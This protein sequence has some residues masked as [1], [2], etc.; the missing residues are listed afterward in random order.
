MKR[1]L[2]NDKVKVISGKW[3]GTEGVVS[4]VLPKKHAAIVAGVNV[5]KRHKK[6]EDPDK[7]IV[8]KTMPIPI[9]KLVLLDSKNKPIKVSFKE[10][11]KIKIRVNR[12]T[13]EKIKK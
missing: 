12:K 7:R 1:I 10:E 2:K 9:C 3:F 6:N 11:D 5:V 4:Q 13:Q 8:E